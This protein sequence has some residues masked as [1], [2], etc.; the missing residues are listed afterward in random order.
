MTQPIQAWL[1]IKAAALQIGTGVVLPTDYGT[2]AA[3]R[4]QLTE[5][6]DAELNP[7][8]ST[9]PGAQTPDAQ[10]GPTQPSTRPGP[11]PSTPRPPTSH[12]DKPGRGPL[13][14]SSEQIVDSTVNAF[15]EGMTR[16]GNRA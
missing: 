2:A 9:P 7:G 1:S 16:G 4:D 6:L 5:Y 15:M 3:L 14:L 8:P 11:P 13:G 12:P 10:P